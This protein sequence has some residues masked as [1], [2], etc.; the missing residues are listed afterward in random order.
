MVS[1]AL[2]CGGA[3]AVA[4]Y[5]GELLKS[6]NLQVQRPLSFELLLRVPG[7]EPVLV[8]SSRLPAAVT[9]WNAEMTVPFT[10]KKKTHSIHNNNIS[11]WVLIGSI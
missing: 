7:L 3:D 5:W 10:K 6:L 9:S 1:D 11:I 2:R 8:L 4:Q